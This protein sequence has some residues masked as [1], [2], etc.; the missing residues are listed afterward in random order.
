QFILMRDAYPQGF[1]KVSLVTPAQNGLTLEGGESISLW[2]G[3]SNQGLILPK[4][5][6]AE[7]QS[8]GIPTEGM[9]AYH[10]VLKKI[11][12]FANN[13][14]KILKS[15]PI[16][17]ITNGSSTPNTSILLGQ[18]TGTNASGI[19]QITE[20]GF[21]K[22]T[23]TN[24][25]GLKNIKYPTESLL[26]Y[27]SDS[28]NI[29][30][31]NGGNWVNLVQTTGTLPVSTSPAA[32]SNGIYLGSNGN[33]ISNAVIQDDDPS[34]GILIPVLRPEDIKDPA[35]GLMIYDNTRH[36]FF[37]FDGSYWNRIEK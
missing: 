27:N 21:I 10:K 16:F 32:Y 20:P 1:A 34:G 15:G 8:R 35:E 31:F 12:L 7:L 23:N 4:L 28:K 22:L 33:K 18:N 6:S 19:V 29:Q 2:I 37:F 17:D 3:S 36:Y 14:W 30:Y 25:E 5:S 26:L 24:E 13:D 11:I 9:M